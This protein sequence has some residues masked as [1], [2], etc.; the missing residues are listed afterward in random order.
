MK[1]LNLI[2]LSLP[3]G[4]KQ[5]WQISWISI[6]R[7]LQVSFLLESDKYR[8][9]NGCSEVFFTA[10]F[11]FEISLGTSRFRRFAVCL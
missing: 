10:P 9:F 6:L 5:A 1:V 4:C 3:E 11:L 8:T 2:E 7:H